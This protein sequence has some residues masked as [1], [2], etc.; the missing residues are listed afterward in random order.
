VIHN[1]L[2]SC[3][4]RLEKA[5]CSWATAA[6]LARH[7]LLNSAGIRA[8]QLW[9][10]Q[11]MDQHTKFLWM[12]ELLDRLQVCHEQLQTAAGASERYFARAIE[13]DLG[14]FRNLCQSLRHEQLSGT[15]S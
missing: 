1:P 15:A 11:G 9:E 7:V 10:W 4:L 2:L 3:H 8:K 6:R 5:I 14:E 13:R 12:R